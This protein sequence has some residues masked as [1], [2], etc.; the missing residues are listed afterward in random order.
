MLHFEIECGQLQI[1]LLKYSALIQAWFIG[2][3]LE[4]PEYFLTARI[5][6]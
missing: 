3:R 6:P 2:K 1:A 4:F 5:Q